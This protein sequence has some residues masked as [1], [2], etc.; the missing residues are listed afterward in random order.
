[1]SGKPRKMTNQ[2]R[3]RLAN[4]DTW[5]IFNAAMEA[6][7]KRYDSQLRAVAAKLKNAHSSS[8]HVAVMSLWAEFNH[9]SS[10]QKR[11]VEAD[12]LRRLEERNKS[13]HGAETV[14]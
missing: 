6:G 11:F 10:E 3:V 13:R 12:A 2:A 8:N 4:P 14:S 9:L 1:M 7:R 5:P